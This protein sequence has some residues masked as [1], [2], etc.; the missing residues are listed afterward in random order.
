MTEAEF[1]VKERPI[2]QAAAWRLLR[3]RTCAARAAQAVPAMVDGVRIQFPQTNF[4][5]GLR[6]R[7]RSR[8]F[9]GQSLM[10]MLYRPELRETCLKL[11]MALLRGLQEADLARFGQ[12]PLDVVYQRGRALRALVLEKTRSRRLSDTQQ[13]V[14]AQLLR[15]YVSARG[16]PRALVH[17]D[18]QASHVI[19]DLSERTIGVIDLEAMRAGQAVTNFAQLWEAYDFADQEHGRLLYERYKAAYP[20][21]V[22]AHFDASARAELALRCLSHLRTTARS[23]DRELRAKAGRLLADVLGD[24]SFEEIC[25]GGERDEHTTRV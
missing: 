6:V 15:A 20:E 18:L 7:V 3:E 4:A 2:G 13:R 16:A 12:T 5:L 10:D 19:V 23:G 21:I 11:G 14:L 24:A 1:V 22:D 25:L 9:A 17:G 8:R